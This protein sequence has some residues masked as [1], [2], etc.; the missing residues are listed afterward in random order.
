MVKHATDLNTGSRTKS[1]DSFGDGS[2]AYKTIM[3]V[4]GQSPKVIIY[5]ITIAINYAN[6]LM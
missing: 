6:E 2:R 5:S 1:D 4:Y 3:K